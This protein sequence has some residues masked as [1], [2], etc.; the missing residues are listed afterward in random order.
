MVIDRVVYG[1]KGKVGLGEKGLVFICRS[2][3]KMIFKL[4][5]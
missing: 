2:F 3:I 4:D 5:I 1:Y